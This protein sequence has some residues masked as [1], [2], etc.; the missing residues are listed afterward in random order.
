[1][2]ALR[3]SR[4]MMR[5]NGMKLFKMDLS[6][7]WYHALTLLASVICYGDALLAAVGIQLPFNA[8]V[9]FFLFYGLYLVVLFAIQYFLR[10][11]VECAYAMAYESICPKPKDDGVVLGSIFDM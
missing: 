5:R 6:F 8:T 3:E 2:A 1:M 7:W 10:N 11:R 4:K 9:A